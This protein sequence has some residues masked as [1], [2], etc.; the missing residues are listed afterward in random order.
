M[1]FLLRRERSGLLV[2]KNGKRPVSLNVIFE[3]E[4]L[5]YVRT[6]KFVYSAGKLKEALAN[7]DKA[8]LLDFRNPVSFAF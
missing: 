6:K 2:L 8:I 4:V 7:A 3:P 5:F 1:K